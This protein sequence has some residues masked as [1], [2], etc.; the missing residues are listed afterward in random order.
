M[1]K[2]SGNID[3]S[4]S[5]VEGQLAKTIDYFSLVPTEAGGATVNVYLIGDSGTVNI[6]PANLAISY[7]EMYEGTGTVVKLASDIIRVESTANVAYNFT[8]N[9]LK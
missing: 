3:G 4:V 7:G 5:S 6:C 8:I 2:F 1:E 9:N